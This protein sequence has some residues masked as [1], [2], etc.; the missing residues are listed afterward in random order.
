MLL[1][2]ENVR[3]KKKLTGVRVDKAGPL[4]RA[5]LGNQIEGFKKPD[6]REAG[7]KNKV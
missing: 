7:R 1:K 4:E 2:I 5:R 3:L 6:H